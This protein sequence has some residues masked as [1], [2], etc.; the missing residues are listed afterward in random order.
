MGYWAFYMG[1]PI[2]NLQ[3]YL[4]P[5]K[6]HLFY[7]LQILNRTFKRKKILFFKKNNDTFDLTVS[8]S[9]V[10]FGTNICIPNSVHF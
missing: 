8:G 1:R 6:E 9:F 4:Y 7:N 10:G 3:L 2:T 5:T